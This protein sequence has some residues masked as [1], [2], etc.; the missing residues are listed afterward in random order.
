MKEFLLTKSYD[1]KKYLHAIC[2]NRFVTSMTF[3]NVAKEVD[4][5]DMCDLLLEYADADA[6]EKVNIA[7]EAELAE[8]RPM[9]A[10]M[11][12]SEKDVYR[13][14]LKAKYWPLMQQEMRAREQERLVCVA[15]E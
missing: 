1:S 2:N 14:L 12:T 10:F 6:L 4:H 13:S 15:K 7:I 5:A 8:L 3:E 9:L 11:K